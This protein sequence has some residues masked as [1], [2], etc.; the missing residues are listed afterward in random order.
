MWCDDDDDDDVYW[1]DKF[2]LRT[3]LFIVDFE[4]KKSFA[5]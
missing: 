4:K 2:Y 3:L 5:Q 1:M